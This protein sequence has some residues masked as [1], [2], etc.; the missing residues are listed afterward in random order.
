VAASRGLA[1][2]ARRLQDAM[3]VKFAIIR[4]G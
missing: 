2:D 1:T 3:G 4:M